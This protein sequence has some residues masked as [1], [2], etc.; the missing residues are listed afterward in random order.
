MCIYRYFTIKHRF[1]FYTNLFSTS[2]KHFYIFAILLLRLLYSAMDQNSAL[3]G[4]ILYFYRSQIVLSVCLHSFVIQ[5]T[6][7]IAFMRFRDP[8]LAIIHSFYKYLP[9][10]QKLIIKL[11]FTVLFNL[12]IGI[13]FVQ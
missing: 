10:Y 3:F 5:Q 1:I 9:L 6:F 8:E 12:L 2:G 11:L 13:K 4:L 7:T